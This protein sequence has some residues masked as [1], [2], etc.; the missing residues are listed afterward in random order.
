MY[1]PD[2]VFELVLS[3]VTDGDPARRVL[4]GFDP[5]RRVRGWK[6]NR[7]IPYTRHLLMHSRDWGA[8][9]RLIDT[10]VYLNFTGRRRSMHGI[11]VI[12][13]MGENNRTWWNL[14]GDWAAGSPLGTMR[15]GYVA[16]TGGRHRLAYGMGS[17]RFEV[18][19]FNNLHRGG[20]LATALIMR[21]CI[22]AGQINI[23]GLFCS[24]FVI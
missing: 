23:E 5:N 19:I 3:Y 6:P 9:R 12:C 15:V 11:S 13:P 14:M 8:V 16:L 4:A 24:V 10:L 22:D 2:L 17:H 1:L 18:D 21:E 7:S 20:R